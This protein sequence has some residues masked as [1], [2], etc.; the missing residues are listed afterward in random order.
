MENWREREKRGEE[1]E[2]ENE[3]RDS[4]GRAQKTHRG[5]KS[6]WALASGLSRIM[7]CAHL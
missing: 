2:T 7:R 3:K 1:R 5:L 6:W 4:R